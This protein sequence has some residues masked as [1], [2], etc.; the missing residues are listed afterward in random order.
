[1]REKNRFQSDETTERSESFILAQPHQ[2]AYDL[3]TRMLSHSAGP[4]CFARSPRSKSSWW[5]RVGL[6]G[7]PFPSYPLCCQILEEVSDETLSAWRRELQVTLEI[8]DCHWLV[9]Q[10]LQF[11]WSLSYPVTPPYAVT[12]LLLLH[13]IPLL[14]RQ[15]T[16][17]VV[18]H[19]DTLTRR[20][21]RR[22]GTHRRSTVSPTWCGSSA[23]VADSSN[24]AHSVLRS[25]QATLKSHLFPDAAAISSLRRS[26]TLRHRQYRLE[27]IKVQARFCLSECWRRFTNV[28]C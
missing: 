26:G 1:M 4:N 8:W 12:L 5:S 13:N 27:V 19:L 17:L 6:L 21:D 18:V 24:K 14:V 22:I 16:K 23:L 28:W 15:P 25:C 11:P 10:F 7:G 3:S 2:A 20:M 9:A